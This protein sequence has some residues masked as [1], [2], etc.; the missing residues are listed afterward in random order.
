MA[1]DMI[2]PLRQIKAPR[3]NGFSMIEMLLAAFILS[4]G[5]LGLA[6]LQAMSLRASRGSS[7]LGTAVLIAERIMAQI[8]QEGRLTWLNTTEENTISPSIAKDLPGFNFKYITLNSGEVITEGFNPK[9][10]PVDPNNYDS[11]SFTSFFKATTQKLAR[12]ADSDGK[13][14]Q[15]NDFNVMVEF[16]ETVDSDKKPIT[17]TLN[18]TRRI[19]HG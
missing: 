10:E 3:Q 13:V 8:E 18:I 19:I 5:I 16:V 15:I 12:G 11:A 1:K 2:S 6:L 7:N 9:G 14:G 17:R 4:I